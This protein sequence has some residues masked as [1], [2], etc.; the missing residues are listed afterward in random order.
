M[1][2]GYEDNIKFSD[3]DY[4]NCIYESGS[5]SRASEIL[6]ISQPALSQCVK[7]LEEEFGIQLLDRK[8]KPFHL[9]IAGEVFYQNGKIIQDQRRKMIGSMKGFA[10]S[11]EKT[12]RIGIS[13]FYSKYY[14]P[15]L[16]P[17]LSQIPNFSF[18]IVDDISINLE[19]K[20]I[21]GDVDLCFLP[22][23]PENSSIF[24]KDLCIEEILIAVPKS[25]EVNKKAISGKGMPYLELSELQDL[26][27]VALKPEQKVTKQ[28]NDLC[29][30]AGFTPHIVYETLDWDTANEMIACS[31][32]VGF[33]PDIVCRR[34]DMQNTPNYYRIV[35][36]SVT[37]RYSAAWA[38]G[39]ELPAIADYVIEIFAKNI[40][41][42]HNP[43]FA[44]ATPFVRLP[45]SDI[46]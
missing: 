5:F 22:R 38:K 35:G 44:L 27:F 18:S 45:F 24:Y 20:L 12:L 17:T 13:P 1:L 11:A 33:V 39:K 42:F 7:K 19:K 28:L 10:T 37:R 8:K 2:T 26:P 4:F 23:E 14:L 9:T 40:Q 30:K 34:G 6:H 36:Q 31:V 43:S 21:S 15:S 3:I 32:G 25:F 16:Y 41:T 29:S 46:H